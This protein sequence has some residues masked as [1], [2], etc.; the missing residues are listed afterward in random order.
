V[1]V[2]VGMIAETVYYGEVAF[3]YGGCSKCSS[4]FEKYHFFLVYRF[5]FFTSIFISASILQKKSLQ[6]IL[7]FENFNFLESVYVFECVK[8]GSRYVADMTVFVSFLR[9]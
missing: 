6:S 1:K 8:H 4:K 9:K 3:D 5:F 2:D 7:E